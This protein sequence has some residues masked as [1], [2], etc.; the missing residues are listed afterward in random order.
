MRMPAITGIRGAMFIGAML[1]DAPFY[2]PAFYQPAFYQ[3]NNATR[4]TQ[5]IFNRRGYEGG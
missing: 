2:Q 1:V 5:H 4:V 3:H